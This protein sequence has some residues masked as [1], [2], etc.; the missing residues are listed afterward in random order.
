MLMLKLKDLRRLK[1]AVLPSENYIPRRDIKVQ[2]L[3]IPKSFIEEQELSFIKMIVGLRN[4]DRTENDSSIRDMFL[5][6]FCH[7]ERD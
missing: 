4:K 3:F 5:T 2:R 6:S 1:K 7:V